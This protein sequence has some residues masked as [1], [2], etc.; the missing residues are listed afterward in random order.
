M[1]VSLLT[2]P[3]SHSHP[4]PHQE[5]GDNLINFEC[6]LTFYYIASRFSISGNFKQVE[7]IVISF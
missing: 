2:G 5:A 7:T 6:L 1:F 3:S 4:R